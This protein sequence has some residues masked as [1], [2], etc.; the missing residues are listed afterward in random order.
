MRLC[1][2]CRQ[3]KMGYHPVQLTDFQKKIGGAEA[4]VS[5][6]LET[7]LNYLP[8]NKVDQHF[9]FIIAVVSPE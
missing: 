7:C 5:G 3:S 9:I 6:T 1:Q 4:R 8:T 2:G